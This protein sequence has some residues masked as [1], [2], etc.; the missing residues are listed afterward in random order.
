[1]A[2]RGRH[3]YYGLKN[4]PII[5]KFSGFAIIWAKLRNKVVQAYVKINQVG[6]LYAAP[7]IHIIA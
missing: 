2:T 4:I 7:I 1:M 6:A 3:S 5:F